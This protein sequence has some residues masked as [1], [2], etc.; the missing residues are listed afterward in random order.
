M[1]ISVGES[2]N[3]CLGIGGAVMR[4]PETGGVVE[5]IIPIWGLASGKEVSIAGGITTIWGLMICVDIALPMVI[6]TL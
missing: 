5:P 1:S 4:G 3:T 6:S 2:K